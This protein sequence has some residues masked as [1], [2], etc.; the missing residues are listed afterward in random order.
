MDEQTFPSWCFVPSL[1]CS[2]T[3]SNCLSHNRPARGCP[4]TFLSRGTTGTSMFCHPSGHLYCGRRIPEHSD[5]GSFSSAGEPSILTWVSA[6]TASLVCPAHPSCLAI[7]SRNVAAVICDADEPCSVNTERD[8]ESSFST[9]HLGV[10]HD[11]KTNLELLFELRNL[12]VAQVQQCRKVNSPF[13][14]CA[15]SRTSF[16]ILT[17]VT[18][19]AG[20]FSRALNCGLRIRNF[21]SL[22]YGNK[23][24]HKIV[25]RS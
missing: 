15:F 16:L 24:A 9:S 23:L 8:P 12:E 7:T 21:Q 19:Q 6:D 3:C 25:I 4:Y 22:V 5:L 14:F 17:F 13:S 10:P 11:P 18:C 2:K 1:I 20:N